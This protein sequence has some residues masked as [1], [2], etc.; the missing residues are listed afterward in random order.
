MT[1][2]STD[3]GFIRHLH[4]FRGFA[5][6][7]ITAIHAFTMAIYFLIPVDMALPSADQTLINISVLAFHDATL[8]FSLISGLL[9]ATVLK[10]RSWRDFFKGKL[11]NVICPY[12]VMTAIFSLIVWPQPME[13]FQIVPFQGTAAEY[14]ALAGSNILTGKSL[15]PM[16]YIPIL[17]VLFVATP[18]LN[19]AAERPRGRWL[20]LALAL[21]PLVVSRTDLEVTVNSVIYFMGAY[22]LGMLAGRDYQ[23]WL[24]W[25]EAHLALLAGVVVI[26]SAVLAGLL[27]G[28]I[29]F[30][31]P[32]SLQESVFYIQKLAAAAIVLAMLR[33]AEA[34]LPGWL[35][36]TATYSF[37]IY[38]LHGP[39]QF[40]M[41]LALNQ[42]VT[43]YPN[44]IETMLMGLVFVV[45]PIG[46]SIAAAFVLRAGLGKRS[47]MIIGT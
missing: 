35:N 33:R 16:Y 31:G 28:E 39:V 37:A 14:L 45:I 29:E 41:T 25:V 26:S 22:A 8:Y 5:I 30:A 19:A 43:R 12:L 32:V 2:H 3:P 23:R 13:D 20:V 15:F 1:A 34:H 24:G 36:G 18:L 7:N 47:R 42:Y 40:F 44:A 10:G 6:I 11:L 17:T 21:L 4:A 46:A 38:F 27:F 9:F